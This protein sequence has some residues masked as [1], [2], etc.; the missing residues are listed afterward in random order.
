M[1]EE[2]ESHCDTTTN[3]TSYSSSC[4]NCLLT[5][6]SPCWC[7]NEIV[8]VLLGLDN[9][10]KSTL[11]S[12]IR[13]ITNKMNIYFLKYNLLFSNVKTLHSSI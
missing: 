12:T 7:R 9:S 1:Q 3:A 11:I 10:G 4:Y 5:F 8:I 2:N 13:F 6:F